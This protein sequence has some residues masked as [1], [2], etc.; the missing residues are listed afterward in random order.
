M[1]AY[2]GPS[3]LG[4]MAWVRSFAREYCDRSDLRRL[5]RRSPLEQLCDPALE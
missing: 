5:S 4:V 3:R 1:F 2:N